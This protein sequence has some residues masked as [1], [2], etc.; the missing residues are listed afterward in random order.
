MK[1]ILPLLLLL[2][3]IPSHAEI[4]SRN[5]VGT[6]ADIRITKSYDTE[7]GIG[8][9]EVKQCSSCSIYNLTI[10]PETKVSRDSTV[11]KPEML[12]TYLDEKRSA[13]MRLQ[14]NKNTNHIT[15]ITLK[16]NNKE[17]PQ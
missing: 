2:L 3:A 1:N 7:T 10:T 5:L 14:F 8:E 9:V 15:F 4:V 13:A 16:R 6:A 11:I 12:Q 17:Y